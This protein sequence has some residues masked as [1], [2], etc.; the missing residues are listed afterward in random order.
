MLDRTTAKLSTPN[1]NIKF[2]N[3]F[4]GKSSWSAIGPEARPQDLHSQALT[5]NESNPCG[6]GFP[7]AQRCKLNNHCLTAK[8]IPT[9]KIG[10]G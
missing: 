2:C 1:P 6:V 4:V 7:P 5:E 3:K 9:K 8:S 10:Y